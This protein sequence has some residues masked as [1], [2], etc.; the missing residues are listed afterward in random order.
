MKVHTLQVDGAQTFT[1][2]G[3]TLEFNT[4]KLMPNL[5]GLGAK[6][7]IQGDINL[8]PL[9]GTTATVAHG[10]GSGVAGFIDLAGGER[11]LDIADGAAEVDVALG[12]RVENGGLTKAGPGTLAF[13]A[14]NPADY[15]TG[16]TN[17][18]AGRLRLAKPILADTA[19]VLISPNATLDLQFSGAL[20]AVHT[21]FINGVPQAP[22]TW[23]AVGSTADFTSPLITGP[24]MLLVGHYPGDYN[25]DGAVSA[26]D[27]ATWRTTFGQA[28][29]LGAGADGN[30]NGVIDAGDYVVWRTY[31]NAFPVGFSARG[32]SVPEPA[33]TILALGAALFALVRRRR[34]ATTNAATACN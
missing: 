2:G 25:G 34:S 29:G 5:S 3:G 17:V 30:K 22:G 21:L 15:Y 14:S 18:L 4:I 10:A 27:Y 31:A 20:D 9:S 28:I 8:S 23:G 1:L 19:D 26:D 32:N 7:T 11:T 12:V 16:D 6:L 33:T 24:G 13:T